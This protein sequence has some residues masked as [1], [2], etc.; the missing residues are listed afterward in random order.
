MG[1]DWTGLKG[2]A[3]LPYYLFWP[4]LPTDA[5]L[6]RLLQQGWQ[7]QVRR[8]TEGPA[9]HVKNHIIE[10]GC[11]WGMPGEGQTPCRGHS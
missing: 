10:V 9:A 8:L 7:T 1:A 2:D 5:R 6:K 11:S 3:A 4:E